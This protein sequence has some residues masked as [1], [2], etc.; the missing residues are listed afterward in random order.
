[1]NKKITK[2]SLFQLSINQNF[3]DSCYVLYRTNFQLK[4]IIL[5]GAFRSWVSFIEFNM[6]E[7]FLLNPIQNSPSLCLLDVCVLSVFQ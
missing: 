7:Q 2:T 6:R 1:M 5:F 3:I 4:K